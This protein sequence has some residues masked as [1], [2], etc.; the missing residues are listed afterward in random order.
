M[1]SDT[2]RVPKTGPLWFTITLT[3]VNGFW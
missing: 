1:T 3:C 2:I